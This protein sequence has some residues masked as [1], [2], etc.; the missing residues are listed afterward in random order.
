VIRKVIEVEIIS[1]IQWA[2]FETAEIIITANLRK[3]K[4]FVERNAKNNIQ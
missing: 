4:R 1:D 3:I 2:P